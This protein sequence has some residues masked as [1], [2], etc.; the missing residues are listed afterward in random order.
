MHPSTLHERRAARQPTTF[1][2]VPR[3]ALMGDRMKLR[4]AVFA[5]PKMDGPSEERMIRV[6]LD[7][8]A[9]V[10]QISCDLAGRRVGFPS[11][12]ASLDERAPLAV[13]RRASLAPLTGGEPELLR[14]DAGT[15]AS[16]L[17]RATML[18][19]PQAA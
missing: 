13:R 5:V 2:Y 7:G 1:K 8:L 4:E 17:R 11:P 16:P 3:V 15:Y 14:A 19:C 9:G 10:R 6:A 12:S 18:P